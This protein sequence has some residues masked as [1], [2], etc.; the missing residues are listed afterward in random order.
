MISTEV[1]RGVASKEV[2]KGVTSKEVVRGVASNSKDV[3]AKEAVEEL[4]VCAVT[5]AKSKEMA[6]VEAEAVR[7]VGKEVPTAIESFV[8]FPLEDEV[9]QEVDDAVPDIS[10]VSLGCP[11]AVDS[12]DSEELRKQM[13]EDAKEL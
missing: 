13:V 5:R 3:V 2:V 10:A 1:V 9:E 4:N 7:A 8:D 11:V 12:P 6:K